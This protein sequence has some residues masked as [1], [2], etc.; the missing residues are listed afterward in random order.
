M[1]TSCK[2]APSMGFARGH[3]SVKA[4]TEQIKAAMVQKLKVPKM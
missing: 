2:L 4:T 1:G 3:V